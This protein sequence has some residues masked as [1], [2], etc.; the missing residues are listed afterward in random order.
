MT[1]NWVVG[2]EPDGDHDGPLHFA[3]AMHRRSRPPVAVRGVYV[4]P[5]AERVGEEARARLEARSQAACHAAVVRTD[6]REMLHEVET[7]EADAVDAGLEQAAGDHDASVCVIGRRA[8][9]REF[10]LQRLGPVARRLLRRLPTAM[11]VVPPDW[12]QVH[13][14]PVVLAT[15]CAEHSRGA[16][17]FA[18]ELAQRLSTPLLVVHTS[19]YGD[20]AGPHFEGA[21][22]EA[23]RARIREQASGALEAWVR[24]HA[25]ED[26]VR[27][28]HL[29][30]P[31]V[32]VAGFASEEKAC[33]IVCGSR[34]LGI[35]ARMFGHSV[36]S[37]LAAVAD[38]PVAVVAP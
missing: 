18:R 36:A 33:L 5:S 4:L 14:G 7:V 34:E 8:H 2:V 27:T 24:E 31:V 17:V 1:R 12:V 16:A 25:L 23:T 9:R 38:V 6:A 30:D 19:R 35:A 26:A 37:E 13:D 15:D 29:G 20:W 28:V 22:F 3:V 10:R 11:V 32:D 21:A